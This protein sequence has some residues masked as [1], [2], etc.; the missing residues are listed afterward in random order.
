MCR[1]RTDDDFGEGPTPMLTRALRRKFQVSV[2]CLSVCVCLSV[3]LFV[4]LPSL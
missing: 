3:C 1:S 4:Y 2:N